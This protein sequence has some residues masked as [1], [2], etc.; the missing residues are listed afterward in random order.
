MLRQ[1][2]KMQYSHESIVWLW[3]RAKIDQVRKCRQMTVPTP[4]SR[5]KLMQNMSHNIHS[6]SETC[7]VTHIHYP[8]VWDVFTYFKL[9]NYEHVP[10]QLHMFVKMHAVMLA[11]GIAFSRFSSDEHQC[12]WQ[13]YYFCNMVP[14]YS[15]SSS[16]SSLAFLRKGSWGRL[17][18]LKALRETLKPAVLALL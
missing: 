1:T 15:S 2:I 10:L 8:S 17:N 12:Y 18:L 7:K 5:L 3:W 9:V 13:K 4:R 14:Q 6:V 16:L 11:C